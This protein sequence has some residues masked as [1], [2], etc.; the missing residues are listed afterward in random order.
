MHDFNLANFVSSDPLA[1]E[2]LGE[3]SPL[4]TPLLRLGGMQLINHRE[5]GH[6]EVGVTWL[7]LAVDGHLS[8]R[9]DTFRGRAVVCTSRVFMGAASPS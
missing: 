9:G 6:R 1:F 7:F 8:C 3:V 2:E 4:E 5:V